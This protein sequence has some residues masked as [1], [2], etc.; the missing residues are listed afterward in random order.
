MSLK[1]NFLRESKSFS[2]G[3]ESLCSPLPSPLPLN[4][5]LLKN[6]N[7]VDFVLY[8]QNVSSKGFL[9]SKGFFSGRGEWKGSSRS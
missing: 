2:K 9:G 4:E 3:D 1:K 7:C 6:F 8:S 5:A